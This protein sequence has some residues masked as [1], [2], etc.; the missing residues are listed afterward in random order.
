[1]SLDSTLRGR[2]R[3]SPTPTGRRTGW[4]DLPVKYRNHLRTRSIET[5]HLQRPGT[6][7]DS[8]P[9][10]TCPQS[11]ILLPFIPNLDDFIS[12]YPGHFL[13]P[14]TVPAVADRSLSCIF[15][16]S[17]RTPPFSPPFPPCTSSHTMHDD[18]RNSPS[19]M[20]LAFFLPQAASV[21]D[22]PSIVVVL[23]SCGC[24]AN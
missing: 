17:L 10:P 7:G 12:N 18:S 16:C 22:I 13:H 1:M 11:S 14:G 23:D 9:P 6:R 8:Q 15:C 19:P 21:C 4:T 20:D 5:R 2:L 24:G 3:A